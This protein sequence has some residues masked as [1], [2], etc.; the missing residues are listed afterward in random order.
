M[1]TDRSTTAHTYISHTGTLR[2][3]RELER[4]A[5]EHSIPT[6][7]S[8]PP[9]TINGTTYYPV[10]T[11]TAFKLRYTPPSEPA[12]STTLPSPTCRR[13][14]EP[15]KQQPSI[16]T[17]IAEKIHTLDCTQNT[18]PEHDNPS[19]DDP[20]PPTDNTRVEVLFLTRDGRKA[21]TLTGDHIHHVEPVADLTEHF[22]PTGTT[23]REKATEIEWYASMHPGTVTPADVTKLLSYP[24]ERTQQSAVAALRYIIDRYTE[25]CVDA[26]LPLREILRQDN[27]ATNGDVLYCLSRLAT[28]TP[29]DVATT[30]DT[31]L[32]HLTEDGTDLT[33][34]ALNICAAVAEHDATL[35]TGY[36][37]TFAEALHSETT[38]T[39]V[40]AARTLASIGETAPENVVPYTQLLR[41]RVADAR[42]FY[43]EKTALTSALSHV[44]RIAPEEIAAHTDVIAAQLYVP[45][46]QLKSNAAAVLHGIANTHP[47]YVVQH[48]DQLTTMIQDGSPQAKRNA[49]AVLAR[50]AITHPEHVSPAAHTIATCLDAD[51]TATRVNA[52][53]VFQHLG[54][55]ASEYVTELQ[56]VAETDADETVR[57][58]ALHAVHSIT[59]HGNL[60][61]E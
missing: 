54:H 46:E 42:D 13:T 25:H 45:D 40:A 41:D 37:E 50:L 55:H 11:H 61:V 20:H 10:E 19:T 24:D 16:R 32:A 31:V 2:N 44:S 7:L 52:C 38:E 48:T 1:S 26:V 51:E 8:N 36:E 56:R 53:W 30:I 27:T 4:E 47:A 23:P 58:R 12:P 15:A 34:D 59:A 6:D 29:A 35:V 49:T 5:W 3:H 21:K 9:I 43:T 14:T 60:T 17:G 39:R 57:K 18:H 28:H 22:N 33:R